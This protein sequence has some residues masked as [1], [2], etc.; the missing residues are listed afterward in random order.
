MDGLCEAGWQ[1][2]IKHVQFAC[3]ATAFLRYGTFG[4]SMLSWLMMAKEKGET[5]WID[6]M[7]Q[8]QNLTVD[9]TLRQW[10]IAMSYLFDLGE[11][12]RELASHL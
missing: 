8:R 1:G 2:Q 4:L 6:E 12:A 7:A 11:E 5:S 3:A 9:E 10:G